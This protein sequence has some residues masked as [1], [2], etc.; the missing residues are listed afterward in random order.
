MSMTD[1]VADMLTRI[2][3]ANSAKKQ[4]VDI[5]ASKLKGQILKV[6]ADQKYIQR[7]TLIET[8]NKVNNIYRVYLKYTPEHTSVISD[9][10]RISRPGLR[11]YVQASQVPK[12]FNGL[13]LAIISTSKGVLSDDECRNNNVGGEVLCYVW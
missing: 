5:P 10:K 11:R 13:G 9:L 2:R 12:V 6:M 7:Y 1:P 3:N 8:S 4:Y